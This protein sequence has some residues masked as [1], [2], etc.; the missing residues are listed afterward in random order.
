M[1]LAAGEHPLGVGCQ[2]PGAEGAGPALAWQECPTAG[3]AGYSSLA[4]RSP[5]ST[6]GFYKTVYA[7]F[8]EKP[9]LP[10]QLPHHMTAIVWLSLNYKAPSLRAEHIRALWSQPL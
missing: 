9:L 6:G 10:W 4:A 2:L 1:F 5:K 7:A 8:G 3:G